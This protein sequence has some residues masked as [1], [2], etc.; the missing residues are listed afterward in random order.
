M[1]EVPKV[2]N[3]FQSGFHRFLWRF[4]RRH[5]HAI[6]LERETRCD[7]ELA[8][9]EP[10]I[11]Y[12]NHPSWWDPLIAHF[13][14]RTLFPKRQFYAPIDAE[15]LEQYPVFGKLG[16]Y[17]VQLSSQ[18]GAAAFLKQSQAILNTK[19]TSIWL[20]PEGQ[21][22]DARD[23]SNPLMPGMAHLA[24]RME[25]GVLVP[26][27]IEYVFWEERLP[28]CL[29]SLGTPCRIGERKDHTKSD[30]SQLLERELR[31]AQARLSG[32]AISRDSEPFDNLLKGKVGAGAGYD[33][34][35]RL[36][37]FGRGTS[38]PSQHGDQFK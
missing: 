12:G 1:T 21:F 8:D 17:G 30:W 14:N 9:D 2:A 29:A 5:F 13:L 24:S 3:W 23:H 34:A 18:S 28:V 25:R 20:T 27:A 31:S 15:A 7:A 38:Q 16:F 35:R 4:L 26:L 11:V 19:N 32:L 6:G 36:R 37:S 33:W 22:A 10:L